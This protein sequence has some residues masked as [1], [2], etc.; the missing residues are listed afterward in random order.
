M[1]NPV[2]L[3]GKRIL[4]VDDEPDILAT[5]V[6][7]LDMYTVDTATSF[8]AA[9]KFLRHSTYDAAIFDIM[10]VDGYQLLKMAAKK[11]VP[12]LMLTSHALTPSNL[13]KS[14]KLGAHIYLPKDRMA[15][16][17]SF[18]EE[19]IQN[20]PTPRKKSGRW[21]IRLLPFFNERFGT[22]WKEPDAGFWNT[23]ADR[24]E[25]S[26]D[27]LNAPIWEWDKMSRL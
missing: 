1:T 23:F 7:L 5:L 4:A 6:E 10:G 14:L 19:L 22:G 16:I 18:L 15:E 12:T 11:G 9:E 8:T 25:V 17:K 13:V 3:S 26:R 24:F 20:K 27:Y 2:S 21:F